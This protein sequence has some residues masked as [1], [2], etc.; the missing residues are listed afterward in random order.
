MISGTEHLPKLPTLLDEPELLELEL[1]VAVAAAELEVAAAAVA[2]AAAPADEATTAADVAVA[3]H[4]ISHYTTPQSTQHQGLTAAVVASTDCVT[5]VSLTGAML[6]KSVVIPK[7]ALNASA[8]PPVFAVTVSAA[9]LAVAHVCFASASALHVFV[10][11]SQMNCVMMSMFCAE[12]ACENTSVREGREQGRGHT[13]VVAGLVDG[14]ERGLLPVV[15]ADAELD[16]RHGAAPEVADAAR[17]RG[18]RRSRGGRGVTRTRRNLHSTPS[19][20]HHPCTL[21]SARYVRQRWR[22]HSQWPSPSQSP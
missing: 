17:A 3:C 1:A 19:R 22:S 10:S 11:V 7:T 8:W 18:A 6:A 4:R 21:R 15:E 14:L 9:A 12:P 2:V 20:Q 13:V 5:P 16:L